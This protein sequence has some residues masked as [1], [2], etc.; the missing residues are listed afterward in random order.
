MGASARI[1]TANMDAFSNLAW[2]VADY[3]ALLA[4]FQHVKGMPQVPGGYYTWRNVDNAFYKVTT[5]LDTV[6]AREALM[7]NILYIN[8]EIDYKRK[9]FNLPRYEE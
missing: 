4:Q 3:E 2:P 1:A 7:D 8:S 5:K 6:T 9:E